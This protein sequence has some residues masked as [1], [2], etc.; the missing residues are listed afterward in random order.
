MTEDKLKELIQR[1]PAINDLRDLAQ[2][3]IPHIAWEY[4]DSGTGD[5]RAVARNIE[6]MAAVTLMPRF[7][8]GKLQP[9]LSTTLFGQTYQAPFGIAPVGLAGLMWPRVEYILAQAAVK[10]SIPYCLSTVATQTPEAIGPLVG[11]MGWF[12]LYP[13]QQLQVRNDLLKRVKD[14]GFNT[15][16]VTADTPMASRRE[17]TTKAG[18]R[19]PPRITPR[20]VYEA[21]RHPRWTVNTLIEGLPRL[22][23]IEKYAPSSSARD[24]ISFVGEKIGGTLSWDYLK[25]VRE[26]WQ[27]PL[28]LKGIL[29]AED[30]ELAVQAGVDGIQVSNHG[31]RQLDAVPAA[32]DV[33]PT[34]VAQVKG[35]VSILFDSGARSGLDI[36]RAIALGADF[37]LLGRAFIYAVAALGKVGGALAIEILLE[38]LK[39]NMVQLGVT[40]LAALRN[41]PGPLKK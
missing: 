13:P 34:I 21:L 16:V 15:L 12:Q 14:A 29:H 37:V 27:G 6:R 2:K 22:K 38:D 10:Y 8:L 28:I 19:L 35:R 24:V 36:A 3:R 25:E 30:A 4:L 31:A 11:D 17:R 23:I 40:K 33:L 9:E 7:M 26:L 41:C 32:I 20:F 1:Y 18:L 5:E 39:N